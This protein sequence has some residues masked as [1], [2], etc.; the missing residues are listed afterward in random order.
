MWK[1]VAA[2][3]RSWGLLWSRATH[4]TSGWR[5]VRAQSL[6]G[7]VRCQDLTLVLADQRR[8][9]TRGSGDPLAVRDADRRGRAHQ[10]DQRAWS[11]ADR[12]RAQLTG[13]DGD[14][15]AAVGLPQVDGAPGRRFLGERVEQLCA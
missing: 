8:A 10:P 15:P 4:R 13:V 14:V 11:G 7:A 5:P 12:V 1:V 6:S 3:P 2:E 9:A